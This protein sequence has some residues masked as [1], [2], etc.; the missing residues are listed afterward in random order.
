MRLYLFTGCVDRLLFYLPE[1]NYCRKPE[2]FLFQVV[3]VCRDE[4]HPHRYRKL[5][6]MNKTRYFLLIWAVL[7]MGVACKNNNEAPPNMVRTYPVMAVSTQDVTGY[8]V[9]PARMQGRNN[10][11]VRAKIS[12]YIREVLVDEGQPVSRGQVLFR[13]ETNMLSQSAN[14]ASSAVQAARASIEAARARV[15]AAQV[16]VNR[17][18]PLVEKNIIS[19]V[20]LETAHANLLQ[21]QSQVKQAEASRMQAQSTYQSARENV[22]YS[23]IRSPI[24]GVVGRLPLRVGS[25]VGPTDPVPLTTVSDVNE[26]WAYF[27]MNER[28]Y[29]NFLNNAEGKTAAEKIRNMPEVTLQLANDSIYPHKGKIEAVT[30]Q[31]D[32]STG[33]ILFRAAFPNAERLLANGNSGRILVPKLYSQ[34]VVIP[35]SATF[36]QQ[37]IVYAFK[38]EKDTIQQVVVNVIDRINNRALLGGGLRVGDTIVAAGIGGLR[39]GVAIKPQQINADSLFNSIK[40]I[41]AK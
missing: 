29:L 9:Y 13:L 32:P 23:I 38:V 11:D 35:E 12:G 19:P 5:N 4:W 34:A 28:E 31:I 2:L 27:S 10:N 7:A 20:Q 26:I 22:N 8:T 41:F 24:N 15:E 39:S 3:T 6:E 16:E 30:G 17:L 40:P 36:E 37:G 25:L 1:D 33:T 21:A 18:K 14:A